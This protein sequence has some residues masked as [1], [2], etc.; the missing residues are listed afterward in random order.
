MF[1]E[2]RAFMEKQHNQL[3]FFIK[4]IEQINKLIN[5]HNKSKHCKCNLAKDIR[6]KSPSLAE[7][8]KICE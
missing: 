2:N 7:Y 1:S 6:E 3:I 4:W 8:D 5:E